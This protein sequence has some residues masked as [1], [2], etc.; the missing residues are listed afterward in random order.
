LRVLPG[1]GEE[2]TI[3]AERV[4]NPYLKAAAIGKL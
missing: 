4:H 3:G 2:T 1:H